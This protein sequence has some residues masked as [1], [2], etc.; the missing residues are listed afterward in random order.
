MPENFSTGQL[1]SYSE[2]ARTLRYKLTPWN[3]KALDRDVAFSR[4]SIDYSRAEGAIVNAEHNG[5]QPAGKMTD[6]HDAEDGLYVT[7]KLSDTTLGRDLF[8]EAKDGLRTG[9]SMELDPTSYSVTNGSG[10]GVLT[11]AGLCVNPA[12]G[13][14]R[15]M[16]A[17]SEDAA[18]PEEP[19]ELT[20]EEEPEE[21]ET[22]TDVPSEDETP[23]ES[24]SPVTENA[25]AP[26]AFA[27]AN[28]GNKVLTAKMISEG[29]N[30]TNFKEAL[31]STTSG[32]AVFSLA[33]I[34]GSA[35]TAN[36]ETQQFLGEL[37]S[38]QGYTRKYAPLVS[39][40]ALTDWKV[41]GWRFV[42]DFTVGDY[43]GDLAEI[44]SNVPTTEYVTESAERLAHGF[45]I[46]RKYLD[47]NNSEF[48]NG[49]F[50][51][52]TEAY[53]RKTD[54][55]VLSRLM[56]ESTS[57]SPSGL[58]AVPAGVAKGFVRIVDGALKLLNDIDQLPTY[59]VVSQ[60]LY[61]E[62]LLTTDFDHL[63]YIATALGISEGQAAG[64]S[65]LPSNKIPED[66]VLIGHKSAMRFFELGGASP[67]RLDAHDLSHAG[68]DHAIYGYY[69]FIVD[70]PKGLL[71][72]TG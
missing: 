32:K 12:L 33:A 55:I 31:A 19:E 59:A 9:I 18:Q 23:K 28:S 53:A 65:I 68:I 67:I 30:D 26:A 21:E 40:E 8:T 61:R 64:I 34:P 66:T 49:L 60:D 46:D 58:G 3:E 1:F 63:S 48:L 25:A 4:G 44:A 37:W 41:E 42:G 39:N 54:S 71:K 69:A 13:S 15:L 29:I 2:N 22:P 7:V 47:F 70:E 24:E 36:I 51:K 11:G 27:A 38:T 57:V 45:K 35:N 72:I 16:T 43:A 52:Q 14:A 6:I 17:F 62:M 10:Q 5:L 56:L 50:R 20:S